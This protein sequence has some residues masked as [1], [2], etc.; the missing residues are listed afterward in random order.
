[1]PN[2][3]SSERSVKT[4]AERRA[5]NFAVR[6]TIRTVSRKVVESVTAG[7]TDEAKALL[8]NAS[9]T[10]DKA[11]SKGVVHK[12]AAARKKS[13]LARKINALAN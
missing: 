9:K 6:S 13:R 3:K 7:N 1:M 4:D 12:N 10:I 8:I 11:A 5:R 2:I